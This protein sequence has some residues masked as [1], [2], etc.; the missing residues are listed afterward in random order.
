M[1]RTGAQTKPAAQQ[2][3]TI[4]IQIERHFNSKVYTS[5]SSIAGQAIVRTQ[6]DTPFD[7]FDIIFTGIA[8]TRLDFVQQYPSHSFRPFMKLRMPLRP[9]AFPESGVFEGGKTYTIPFNFVVPH[10]LT[11]AACDH[12]CSTPVVREQHLRLPPTVGFWE[13]DDQAPEMAQIEYS[14]KAR[15]YRGASP[16]SPPAKLMEGYRMVKV[17]PA[18]P[19]DAPLDITFRDKRYNLS[20][21][22]TIRKN[23]FSAKAG[24][25]TATATQPTAVMLAA[26]GCGASTSTARITL[27]FASTSAETVPPKINSVSGKITASTF[28][29]AA[30]TDLLPNLGSRSAYTA[31]PSLSYTTT[32][33][34]FSKSIDKLAWQQRNVSSRRD[35]GY[36]SLGVEEDAS[37]TD[38]S[39]GRGRTGGKG[40]SSKAYPMEH[41][42]VLKIPFS[43]PTSSRK[44]FLPTF[45]SCLISRTYTLHLSLSFGPTNTAMS[46]AIPLQIGVETTHQPHFDDGLPSFESA[47]AADEEAEINA[48][49]QPRILRVLEME[50]QSN[51]LPP[52]YDELARQMI[53]VA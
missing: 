39:E 38:C 8:A 45:H 22:K 6:R 44:L 10:Q 29:G 7:G 28:F 17:L 2:K 31:N 42:T 23:L 27:R 18:L 46:L 19:E 25:L 36:S 43:I 51:S 9:S 48:H 34:L 11:L 32:T 52:G 4:D 21:S 47:M 40:K 15:A 12:R 53:S 16:G 41:T 5:G 30:P 14:I 50:D 1:P 20:K 13:A 26:D 33:A 37:E 3:P 49:L 35:S 24:K